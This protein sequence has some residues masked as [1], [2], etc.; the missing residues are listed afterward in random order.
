MLESLD[1]GAQE[2]ME[3]EVRR[4]Q[5]TLASGESSAGAARFQGG[6]GRHGR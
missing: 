2:A 4:G 3:N 1:L 6:A 5:Q